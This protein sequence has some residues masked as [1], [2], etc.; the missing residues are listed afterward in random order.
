MSEPRCEVIPEQ[1]TP[2]TA[3]S[4]GFKDGV[5]HAAEMKQ[6]QEILSWSTSPPTQ[7]GWWWVKLESLSKPAMAYVY[8]NHDGT[9][10][11]VVREHGGSFVGEWP[12]N[13]LWSPV[14]PPP[15]L[16]EEGE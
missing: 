1:W 13:A 14:V 9:L 11:V 10:Y 7:P 4:E 5:N 16:P 12:E 8:W 3:Y 15:P 2:A 6:L